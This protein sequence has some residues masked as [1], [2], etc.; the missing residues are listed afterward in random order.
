MD[1]YQSKFGKKKKA[2]AKGKVKPTSYRPMGEM[3][4]FENPVYESNPEVFAL[5]GVASYG[6]RPS[7]DYE[8]LSGSI[9][10]K[11]DLSEVKL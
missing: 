4:S 11:V 10:E 6:D 9:G 7:N 5:P 2:E 8:D 1:S 3:T